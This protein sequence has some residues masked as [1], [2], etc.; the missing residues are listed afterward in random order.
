VVAYLALFVALGGTSFAVKRL[1]GQDIA[2]RSIP[3]NRLKKDSVGTAEVK[4]LR[5]KDFRKGQLRAGKQ[6]SPGATGAPGA[7]AANALLGNTATDLSIVANQKLAPSGPTTPISV[8]MAGNEQRSPNAPIV[9]RDLSMGVTSP[10]GGPTTRTFTLYDDGSPTPVSCTIAGS[11]TSCDS[12]NAT[13]TI[14]PGS[15]LWIQ[16][17]LTVSPPTAAS[18]SWGWRAT[19]P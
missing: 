14:S 19:T 2:K 4:G 1:D 16:A 15:S 7:S 11:Q 18:A 10:P 13:A 8:T 17:S 6:G 3:G 9:A 5:A 12:G